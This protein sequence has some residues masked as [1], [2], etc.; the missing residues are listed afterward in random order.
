[1]TANIIT[2]VALA[3]ALGASIASVRYAVIAHRASQRAQKAL[4]SMGTPV[5]PPPRSARF[6]Q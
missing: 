3:V 4:R 5:R 1:M 6:W 2:W